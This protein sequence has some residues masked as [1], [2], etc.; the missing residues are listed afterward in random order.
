MSVT[1]VLTQSVALWVVFTVTVARIA[2]F[3][4][5][6]YGVSVKTEQLTDST[7]LS[8]GLCNV[9]LGKKKKNFLANASKASSNIFTAETE[10]GLNLTSCR[11]HMTKDTPQRRSKTC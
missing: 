10:Q 6:L 8:D 11:H 2:G 1:L 5:S 9:F 7:G 4:Q 3:L